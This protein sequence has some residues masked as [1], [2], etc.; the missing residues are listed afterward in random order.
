M[1]T[2]ILSTLALVMS[3]SAGISAAAPNSSEAPGSAPHYAN[4]PHGTIPNLTE[5]R[6]QGP[7]N[8]ENSVQVLVYPETTAAAV[9]DLTESY[10]T[11]KAR[12]GYH[13]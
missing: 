3:L 8:K 2:P 13:S 10:P 9:Q 11:L 12:G 4:T 6:V 7:V 5:A 1:K